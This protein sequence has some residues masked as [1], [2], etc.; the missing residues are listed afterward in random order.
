MK[1][2]LEGLVERVEQTVRQTP[3]K[4]EGGDE[5]EAEIE[6]ALGEGVGCDSALCGG[7]VALVETAHDAEV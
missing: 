6:L 5:S 7:A 3:D 4:E 1:R 2:V